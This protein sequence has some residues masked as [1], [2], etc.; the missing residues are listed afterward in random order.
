MDS[1]GRRVEGT[2]HH[3][4]RSFAEV[5]ITCAIAMS[6]SGAQAASVPITFTPI[7]SFQSEANVS[8]P[9]QAI[10]DDPRGYEL[11]V[12]GLLS[13]N[14]F[15]PCGPIGPCP[16]GSYNVFA[17]LRFSDPVA[18]QSLGTVRVFG[19]GST[20]V[21]PGLSPFDAKFLLTPDQVSY[22]QGNGSAALTLFADLSVGPGSFQFRDIF[23]DQS[24]VNA[25]LTLSPAQ[26]PLP[27]AG[28]LMI[29]GLASLLLEGFRL[30]SRGEKGPDQAPRH[31]YAPS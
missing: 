29:A 9:Q 18:F 28:W 25:D 20:F 7:N 11:D 13:T 15:Y 10:L 2:S 27:A 19:Y 6:A 1:I 17:D 8:F 3:W 24:I 16:G 5:L 4:I 22:F 23:Y 26:L 31:T 21:N 12:T 14:V 30:R